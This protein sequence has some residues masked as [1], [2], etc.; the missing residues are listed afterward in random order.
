MS[1]IRVVLGPP[2][3][4]KT[5]F[6]MGEIDKLLH[7]GVDPSEIGFY[8]FTRAACN[9]AKER[10]ADRFGFDPEGH[11]FTHWRTLHSQAYR[12]IGRDHGS[13]MKH[14]HW[15]ELG[16][17][18]CL[19]FTDCDTMQSAD[20]FMLA[21]LSTDGDK[22]RYVYDLMRLCKLSIDATLLR[23]GEAGELFSASVITS[24]IKKY[25]TF[26]REKKLLD[27]VDMLKLATKTEKRPSIRY[28]FFD[29]AQDNCA[30]Q[31]ELVQRWALDHT[32]CEETVIV[33]DDDQAIYVWSGAEPGILI[34]YASKHETRVLEQSYRIPARVHGFA[35]RIIA[36]NRA[37]LPKV[38]RPRAEQGDLFFMSS[39]ASLLGDEDFDDRG[40]LMVLCRNIMFAE[41]FRDECLSRGR[42]FTCEVGAPSPLQSDTQ[43]SAFLA[44]SAILQRRP[45]RPNGFI[46]MLDLIPTKDGDER[47]LPHGVK[48]AAARNKG[49]VDEARLVGEFG[50]GSLVDRVRRLPNPFDVFAKLAAKERTY[51]DAVYR[52]DPHLS[53]GGKTTITSMH[54]SKGREASTV[55]LSPDCTSATY[56]QV[57]AGDE[58]ENRV[59]YVAATRARDALVLLHPTR[60]QHYDYERF[61]GGQA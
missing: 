56:R 13:V 14:E 53:G 52:R 45:V 33:G 55:V 57:A 17:W 28:A 47:V 4:G 1:R 25:E 15:K 44:L 37:R 19:H 5:T 36:Q 7:A 18:A 35:Q 27:F 11:E 46:H 48:T 61:A 42:T 38:Y 12:L 29:E 41:S 34:D 58:S 32:R 8:S 16:E 54:R 6:I 22:L 43:R 2:G 30:L 31:A 9:E 60:K 51:L 59:A 26:K 10:A 49:L 21:S 20:T 39:L 23:A 40:N 50:L 3:T 24:F